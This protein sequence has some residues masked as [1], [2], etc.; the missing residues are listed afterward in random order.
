MGLLSWLFPSAEDRV[1]SAKKAL[2]AGRWRDAKDAVDGLPGP[3]AEAVRVEADHGLVRL[4]LKH[5]IDWAEAGED[6]RIEAHFELIDELHH[7]GLEPEIRDTR[8]QVREIRTARAEEARRKREEEARQ[9]QVDPLGL[10]GKSLLQSGSTALRTEEDEHREQRLALI[11]ENYPSDLRAGAITLGPAFA[12]ALLDLEEGR[13]DLALQALLAL[14]DQSPLVCFERA[15]CA[16]SLNDPQAAARWLREFAAGAGGHRQIGPDHT[17]FMLTQLLVQTEDLEGGIRVLRDARAADPNVGGA[18]LAELLYVTGVR[19]ADAARLAE[20]E[21]LLRG[22]IQ[23]APQ[24]GELY[25]LLAKVRVAGGHREAAMRAYEQ[26]LQCACGKPGSCGTQPANPA[27]QRSLATLYLEDGIEKDRALELAAE[28]LGKL[29]Q[30]GWDDVYLEA[31]VARAT[32]QSPEAAAALWEH[33][34]EGDPR[35]S[36]L[37]RYLPQPA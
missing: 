8:R 21:E 13:P 9:T 34:P 30:P 37:E 24:T 27:D 10:T 5:V 36:R 35:R 12:N 29:Q 6:E 14:P 2:A 25:S 22:A 31:L 18:A 1:A 23:K 4:N 15:R 26:A 33:T 3:E 16:W 32:G 20:A 19:N 17:A 11:L 7:G 28:A